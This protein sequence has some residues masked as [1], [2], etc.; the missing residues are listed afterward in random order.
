MSGSSPL[1]EAEGCIY[2]RLVTVEDLRPFDTHAVVVEGT[3]S[4]VDRLQVEWIAQVP[5]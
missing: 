4:G 5:A 1:L 3:L 2:V